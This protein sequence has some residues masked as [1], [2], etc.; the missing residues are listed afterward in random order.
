[1]STRLHHGCHEPR[2]GVT[3]ADRSEVSKIVNDLM[4]R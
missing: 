2:T 4:R 3:H 1:M